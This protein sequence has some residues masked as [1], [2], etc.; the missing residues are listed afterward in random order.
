MNGRSSLIFRGYG[1]RVKVDLPSGVDI[2][3]LKRFVAPELTT[4]QT[5]SRDPSDI[6]LTRWNGTFHLNLGERRYGPYRSLENVYRGVSNGIHFVLGK[7]SP[8][9]FLHA[10]AVE[11]DGSAVVFPGRSRWGK[12][13]LVSSLV[14]QGCGYL[15]DEYAVISAD[16]AVFPFSKPIRLRRETGAEYVT[17]AGVSEPG[18]L[19]CAAV[20]LTQYEEGA[21]WNPEPL[22]SGSAILG[23][24]PFALQ[25][26]DAPEQVLE[27]VAAM[28]RKAMC[29]E[30]P[31]GNGEPTA[32]ALREMGKVDKVPQEMKA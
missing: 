9:T 14:E 4:E 7:R 21:A 17:P 2:A 27:A 13:M 24:L 11:V 20:I 19:P 18:G 22:T 6:L 31:R 5:N 8:M 12:S 10:G 28:V 3:A 1:A 23:V 30:G 32:A 25:S 15:S 26:R 29:Y 16:G